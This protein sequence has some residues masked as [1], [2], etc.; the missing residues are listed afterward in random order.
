LVGRK[1]EGEEEEENESEKR[2]ILVS[3]E[4][5]GEIIEIRTVIKKAKVHIPSIVRELECKKDEK[6]QEEIYLLA[7]EKE[8]VKHK[9]ENGAHTVKKVIIFK[10]NR[11]QKE[12]IVDV[13]TYLQEEREEGYT[14]V[15]KKIEK[16]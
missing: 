3:E 4:E 5:K 1:E 15:Y 2:E 8:E 7:G 10:R 14:E 11:D 12:S 13:R 9:L 16:E 6:G